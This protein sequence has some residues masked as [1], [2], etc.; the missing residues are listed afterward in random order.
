MADVNETSKN[1]DELLVRELK[2]RGIMH[3]LWQMQTCAPYSRR[4]SA[5]DYKQWLSE[6]EGNVRDAHLSVTCATRERI[7][8]GKKRVIV[9]DVVDVLGALPDAFADANTVR[10]AAL[11]WGNESDEAAAVGEAA[12]EKW[13]GPGSPFGWGV[14]ESYAAAERLDAIQSDSVSG[15]AHNVYA[16]GM[17]LACFALT[18]AM[19]FVQ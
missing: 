16:G 17:T 11:T 3:V 5:E 4:R 18:C 6:G 10:L 14:S 8:S 2:N 13:I 19:S 9:A 15:G 12:F 1:V 7:R